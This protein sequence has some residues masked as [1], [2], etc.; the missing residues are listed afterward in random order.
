MTEPQNDDDPAQLEA[1][2]EQIRGPSVL[3]YTKRAGKALGWFV[4]SVFLGGFVLW[5]VTLLFDEPTANQM[6][7]P[8]FGSFVVA[9]L[10]RGYAELTGK[11]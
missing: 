2:I 5:L 8:I 7:K 6:A 4:I 9:G 10:A 3:G 1:E 11:T